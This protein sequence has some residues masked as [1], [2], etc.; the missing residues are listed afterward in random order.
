MRNLDFRNPRFLLAALVEMTKW[1]PPLPLGEGW[2]EGNRQI[3]RGVAQTSEVCET[4]EVLKVTSL[5][6]LEP[7][8]IPALDERQCKKSSHTCG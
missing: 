3:D 1:Q 8:I 6:R 5:S 7:D 4:S 2:G